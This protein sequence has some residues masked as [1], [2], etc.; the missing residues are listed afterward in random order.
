MHDG[1]S[2]S[3]NPSRSGYHFPLDRWGG[4]QCYSAPALG[5]FGYALARYVGY[6]VRERR[7]V[8]GVMDAAKRDQISN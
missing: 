2:D 6:F 4:F 7:Y 8:R 1:E 3:G 5:V